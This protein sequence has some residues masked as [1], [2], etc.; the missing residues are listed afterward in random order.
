MNIL[1]WIAIGLVSFFV[2]F[3]VTVLLGMISH[4]IYNVFMFGWYML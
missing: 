3:T 1:K 4:F 2:W